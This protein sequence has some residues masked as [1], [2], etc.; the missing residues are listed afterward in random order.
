MLRKRLIPRILVQ[1]FRNNN[2]AVI[3]KKFQNFTVTGDPESQFKILQSNLADEVSI[4]NLHRG[5]NNPI[6]EFV[7]LLSIIVNGSSTP[8]TSGG[9]IKL[10]VDVDL[11]MGTGIEKISIPILSNYSNL[12]TIKYALGQYGSQSIQICLDYVKYDNFYL[13][14]NFEKRFVLNELLDLIKIYFEEGAGEI[15]LTDINKDGS[16]LGL[17]VELI[18][19]IKS[20]I[21]A[22]IIVAGG[23]CSISDFANA[24]SLGADGVISGTYFAKKDHSL[25]QLRSA[26]YGQGINVRNLIS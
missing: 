14:R 6:P 19:P 21:N 18:E 12:N 15:V 24:L 16:K 25:I 7:K 8:I 2:V 11:F 17:G 5:G 4:I 9:G 20:L 1:R 22:P 3:S 10:P 23:A 13:I 26:I